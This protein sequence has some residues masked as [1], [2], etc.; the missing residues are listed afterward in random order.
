MAITKLQLCLNFKMIVVFHVAVKGVN[1]FGSKSEFIVSGSDCGHIYMWEHD[2]ESIIQFML[3][4][5][6]GVVSYTFLR[7]CTVINDF[8]Y[9]LI[10]NIMNMNL[11]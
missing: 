10:M 3:G 4:D 5:E 11:R 9:C 1:Y 8:Y 6:G 2:S 7:L